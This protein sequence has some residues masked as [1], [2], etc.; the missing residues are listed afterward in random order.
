MSQKFLLV[1]L[2][3]F[4]VIICILL[5]ILLYNRNSNKLSINS[6]INTIQLSIENPKKTIKLLE[7]WKIYSKEVKLLNISNKLYNVNSVNIILTHKVQPYDQYYD[8]DGVTVVQSSGYTYNNNTLTI[9]VY[10]H[11][12][13]VLKRDNKEVSEWIFYT[14]L[15]RLRKISQGGASE[16]IDNSV[17]INNF[18]EHN[19][20]TI[21][22]KKI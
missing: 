22:V 14:S 18:I 1:L 9:F 4:I 19:N 3:T 2:G 6:E 16:Y 20:E 8:V 15:L 13:K 17:E 5:S 7:D 11:P 12:E 10:L 21:Q